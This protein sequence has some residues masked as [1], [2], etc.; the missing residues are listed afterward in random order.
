MRRAKCK[1]REKL[2]EE[3]KNHNIRILH[4][5]TNQLSLHSQSQLNIE[6]FGGGASS[7]FGGFGSSTTTNNSPFG[8]GA[9][10]GAA[11]TNTGASPFGSTNT[12][13]TGGGI[14]GSN[15]NSSTGF[16]SS[17]AFGASSNTNTT[18]AF[19]GNTGGGL[20]GSTANGTGSSPFGQ[21]QQQQQPQQTTSAF[22]SSNNSGS[23]FGSSA[24]GGGLFG[25]KPATSTFGGFGSTTANASSPFGASTTNA[26]GG[27][28]SVDPNVNNGTAAKQF[29]PFTEKDSANMTNVF[30]NICCMP[31]YKNFSFEELRLKDYEQG[32]RFP[33][34]GATANA[35]FGGAAGTNATGGGLGL[36]VLLLVPHL[37]EVALLEQQTL[38]AQLLG[39][40]LD[41]LLATSQLG[42]L[43]LGLLLQQVHLEVQIRTSHLLVP[44]QQELLVRV[45]PILLEV[46]LTALLV[47]QLQDLVLLVGHL[48]AIRTLEE[49]VVVYLGRAVMLLV[50]KAH[51][52]LVLPI[53][54]PHLVRP[55][56][57]THLVVQTIIHHLVKAIRNNSQGGY[58][59]VGLVMHLVQILA[60]LLLVQTIRD[61]ELVVMLSV[62]KEIPGLVLTN[63]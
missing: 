59:E 58:L 57:T 10:A 17:N 25:S 47:N 32:R 24:T 35:G 52:D 62:N 34:A 45:H 30:Q 12:N 13:T 27:G 48:V 43:H 16:G 15:A 23:V 50:V 9:G 28:A 38:Q 4:F 11:T 6:M 40:L 33:P 53:I 46:V 36:V 18:P 8:G 63:Q 22:G 5:N 14:F 2:R 44:I 3:K 21:Q 55:N 26:F 41:Q 54:V 29:T 49:Q 56:Q 42:P 20:F 39:L 31:E 37:L 19:G 1:E 7:G 60:D 51:R 61:L